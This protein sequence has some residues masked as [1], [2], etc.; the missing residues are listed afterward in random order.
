MRSTNEVASAGAASAGACLQ[1]SE[2]D[3][4]NERL[5]SGLSRPVVLLFAVASGLAV[6]NAYFAHPLLDVMADD[7][8]I[9]RAT[10]GLIVGFTQLGYGLGLVLLV[11]LGDLVDRRKLV[12]GQSLLSVLAL[13]SVGF[14]TTGAM[15]LGSMA[16]MGLM[17]VVT[18]ALVAYA[19][20]LA[21]PAERGQVVGVVTSGIV[22]G[23]LLAR[24]VAG[25]LTDLSGW[26]TV[27]FVSAV[28]TLIIAALLYKVLPAQEPQNKRMSYPRLIG[29]LFTLFA[30]EPVLRIRAIIAMLIFADIT[31]LLTPLVL[32]L[33]AP[34]F[35][36]SHTAIGLF[37]L[38]G[39]AGALGA[40]RAGRWTDRGFGQR[41]TGIAL[42]LMLV[43]WLPIAL[44]PHSILWLIAGVL[45]I[46][47]GLQAVHVTNQGMIYR[48]RP[49]AQSR[50]TAAYMVFYS[51]GSALGSS[52]STMIYA[53]AGWT[54]VC[55][56]G[57]GISALAIAF[58]AATLRA[59][60]ATATQAIGIN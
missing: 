32:P 17:A 13:V 22:L 7:L 33:S 46:D 37:G 31:T 60:P 57:A 16:A 51:I 59:T 19:A 35:S 43:A 39:A 8:G 38:A 20:S 50:L 30:E 5:S 2:L 45:I 15:L 58:W 54:G 9:A 28:L 24:T 56:L 47:F 29:S 10:A 40:A 18:Q 12:V 4:G 6:A 36:L 48:V 1:A 53:Y 14:S 11:P 3:K 21:R 42:A 49:E 41:T 23:I 25:T 27:Y 34:P 44:L 52:L 55:L 26:R